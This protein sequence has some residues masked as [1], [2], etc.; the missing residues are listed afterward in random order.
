[1]KKPKC[2]HDMKFN[3][4]D[5]RNEQEFNAYYEDVKDKSVSLRVDLTT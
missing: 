5:F 4:F 3:S 1:M 2:E